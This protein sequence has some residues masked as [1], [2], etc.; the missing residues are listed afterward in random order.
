ME[1][2][3]LESLKF[4]QDLRPLFLDFISKNLA[5]GLSDIFIVKN[6]ARTRLKRDYYE[7]LHF[8]S[9][10]L[11]DLLPN[12]DINLAIEEVSKYYLSENGRL[13]FEQYPSHLDN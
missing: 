11:N 5:L 10:K 6:V 2:N 12:E 8:L 7:S 9:Q 13:I 3:T 4:D 1:Y